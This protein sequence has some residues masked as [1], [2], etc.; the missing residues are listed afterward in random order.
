MASSDSLPELSFREKLIRILLYLA[1]T[2][3][4]VYFLPREGKFRYHFQEG[5]PWKY[6]LLTASFDFPVYKT[7]SQIQFERDS[8]MARYYPYYKMD[9][10]I[11]KTQLSQL[12]NDYRSSLQKTL[13]RKDYQYLVT[14]LRNIYQDG[15]L[16][17]NE[18]QA[19]ERSQTNSVRILDQNISKLKHLNTLKSVREAYEEILANAP[20]E[21]SRRSLRSSNIN[22]YLQENL[23]LDTLTSQ[24]VK[25]ELLQT[26]S[27][28]SGLVQAGERIVDRGEIITPQTYNIL[29]SLEIV[30]QKRAGT[31]GQQS[32]TL[33]GQILISLL[34]LGSLLL[35]QYLYRP[36]MYNRLRDVEVVLLLV[37]TMIMLCS[38]LGHFRLLSIYLVPFAIVPIV[39]RTF[40][41][42]R[43][44][45]FAHIITITICSFLAPFAFEFFLLQVSIGITTIF[46]LKE[47]TQRSQLV[48]VAVFVFLTY[49]VVY[50]SY[51]LIMES[52]WDKINP[53]M[54]VYFLINATLILFAYLLIFIL[55]KTLGFT[56]NV[57][58]VELSNI[59]APLLRRLSEECPGTFQHSLQI[60]NLCAQAAR[61]I[62]AN[63][64]LIRTGALY[65][66]IG[67]LSN[68]SFFTENQLDINPHDKLSIEQSVGIIKQHVSDGLKLAQRE[69][70]PEEIT[71][72]ITTHHGASKIKYFYTKWKNDHPDQDIDENIFHYPGP[73]PY[74]KEQALLMM[75]D[76]IEAA[77]RSLKVYN[78]ESFEKL[79][80]NLIDA[81]VK[82]GM[83]SNTPLTF[84]DLETIKEVFIER[85]Q[86]MYHA[87]I[88]YPELKNGAK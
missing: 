84:R 2:A 76:C 20:S 45:F 31:T 18:Q 26:I 39:I 21:E 34:L 70:L 42:S 43:V 60:S 27:G 54:F 22:H 36:E 4:V 48:K 75:A 13:S 8:I 61:R 1:A 59:N 33:I 79:V 11:I 52:N 30:N 65:H 38:F 55:E 7:D 64:N 73:N 87:R 77:S 83:F 37:T 41:D 19:L 14:S 16:S 85:L 47:L 57:T 82:E 81:Q 58:L 10:T 49:T 32:L 63:V 15:I 40:L 29:R 50:V 44:A 6:G 80:N 28:S 12:E 5:K 66:D 78:E 68:P 17:A 72:F 35:F 74:T 69:K 3:I 51:A 9:K 23:T 53:A 24:K 88:S 56:S 25:N 62:G 67:K 46:S 86:T 71:A